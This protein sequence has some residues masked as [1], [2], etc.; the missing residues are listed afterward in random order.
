MNILFNDVDV[1]LLFSGAAVGQEIDT[2]REES[3]CPPAGR[4]L[5]T[6]VVLT[7]FKSNSM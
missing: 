6:P 2:Y 4:D 3:V 5:S 7:S 1:I